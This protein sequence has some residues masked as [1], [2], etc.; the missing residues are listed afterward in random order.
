[1]NKKTKGDN[2]WSSKLGY[3]LAA[4]GAA[5]GLGN[6]W[7]FPYITGE[8]GGGAFVLVYLACIILIGLPV[9]IAEVT[10]GKMGKKSPINS[11]IEIAREARISKNWAF[12]GAMGMIAG[13]LVLSFYSVITGWA[14]AYVGYGI[15]GKFTDDPTS[16]Q[17]L[18]ENLTT[19]G[20]AL[21]FLTIAIIVS[22]T[23]VT[24]KGVQKGLEKATSLLMPS[25]LFLLVFLAIYASFTGSFA[26]SFSFMFSPDFS[27]LT[28]DSVIMALG[29]AF[30]TLSLA[31]GVM[32]MYGAYLPD[33]V[34]VG[35]SSV[36][37][38][39]A[40]TVV[41]FVAGFAIF[42]IVF[43]Y[44]LDPSQG[45][46]LIFI[47]LPIAFGT[48]PFGQVFGTLF[49]VM[50]VFAAFT[51]GIALLESTVSYLQE[52]FSWSRVKAA[53]I[54]AIVLFILS[55][56]SILSFV[57]S[58]IA[59][60]SF[61]LGFFKFEKSIFDSLDYLTANI[62]LPVG[63]LLISVLFGFL[64]DKE[65][66]KGALNLSDR[67]N[68]ILFLLLRYFA[69]VAISIVFLSVIGII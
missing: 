2:V 45:P 11:L 22:I 1:M 36:T 38:A 53:V 7:K 43:S 39:F 4:T 68:T 24:I 13:Y 16:M 15:S 55:I 14:L 6:V 25:L 63:G 67:Q 60:L 32:L 19:N 52:K 62:L 27:K 33:D 48:M 54:S 3:V 41:A 61:D 31:S 42:P 49:F 59:N 35:K 57:G 37:I 50:I 10:L 46:G 21:V 17:S 23:F 30:F 28:V 65:K 26:K 12:I 5:V 18:F 69:P 64:V 51:S 44:G 29:H 58:P 40:D 8:N 9:M 20:T 34:S 47:T 66:A 56:G